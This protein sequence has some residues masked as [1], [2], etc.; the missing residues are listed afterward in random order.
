MRMQAA[1]EVGAA[2][3]LN[4]QL[5]LSV[6]KRREQLHKVGFYPS[7]TAFLEQTLTDQRKTL[8]NIRPEGWKSQQL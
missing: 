7:A 3:G 2:Q 6:A 8:A 1:K 5:V 4:Q